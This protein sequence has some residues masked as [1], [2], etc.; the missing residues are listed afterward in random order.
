VDL[1]LELETAK[2]PSRSVE[3]TSFCRPTLTLDLLLFPI[4]CLSTSTACLR[5]LIHIEDLIVLDEATQVL[6]D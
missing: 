2:L 1:C 3:R 4:D 5:F 6:I